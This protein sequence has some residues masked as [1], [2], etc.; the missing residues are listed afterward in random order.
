ML[1]FLATDR[2]YPTEHPSPAP[3]VGAGR[4]MNR[5]YMHMHISTCH[6]L[7]LIK[8]PALSPHPFPLTPFPFPLPS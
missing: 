8:Q 4:F 1:A 2:S 5:P 7:T 3:F 6:R